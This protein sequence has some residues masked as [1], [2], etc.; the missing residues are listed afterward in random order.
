MRRTKLMLPVAIVL[1]L[2]A[3]PASATAPGENGKIAFTSTA[4]P[5]WDIH[6]IWPDPD[7]AE[8]H[9]TNLTPNPGDDGAGLVAGRLE[10]RLQQPARAKSVPPGS[11][12]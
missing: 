2:G 4:G 1:C 8:R 12:S 11:G 7:P 10:D 5:S 9:E 3:A 6:T